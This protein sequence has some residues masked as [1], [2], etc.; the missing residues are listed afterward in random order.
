MNWWGISVKKKIKW[1]VGGG[2]LEFF[3]EAGGGHCEKL[4]NANI[5][6][7]FGLYV[8]IC[9]YVYVYM[10]EVYMDRHI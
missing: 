5:I 4:V 1:W 10:H 9:K 2:N 8:N 6:F 7:N 3:K